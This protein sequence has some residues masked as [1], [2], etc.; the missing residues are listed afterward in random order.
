[1]KITKE[2][3]GGALSLRMG[4]KVADPSEPTLTLAS[5]SL[6]EIARACRKVEHKLRKCSPPPKYDADCEMV[7]SAFQ[8][9]GGLFADLLSDAMNKILL[10]AYDSGSPNWE[11]IF[12]SQTVKN[13]V[14]ELVDVKPLGSPPE[15]AEGGQFGALGGGEGNTHDVSL[16]KHGGIFSV[17]YETILADDV[18][19]V[20]RVITEHVSAAYRLEDDKIF[21]LLQ[22]P[23]AID[24]K[25]FFSAA[26]GNKKT[27]AAFSGANLALAVQ[28]LRAMTVSGVKLRLSPAAL[29]VPPALEDS[30]R[31]EV[32]KR[33]NR[34]NDPDRIEVVAESRLTGTTWFLAARK[35]QV[36]ALILAFLP[37]RRKPEIITLP[38]TLAVDGQ[39]YRLK[40]ICQ[41]MGVKPEGIIQNVE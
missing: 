13:L 11:R 35:Q 40:H 41:A 27:G 2:V 21:E 24:G 12:E 34:D 7:R 9:G 3:L 1:M 14:G 5:H 4:L 22:S 30:A 18:G 39:R 15:I 8:Y 23:P 28:A 31:Q 17:S 19:F 25:A 36:S 32:V 29:I 6:P 33:F 10:S 26:R 16:K 20:Q 38:K 37:E